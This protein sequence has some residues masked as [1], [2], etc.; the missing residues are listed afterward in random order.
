MDEHKPLDSKNGR[1]C[2]GID[3]RRFSVWTT[4]V[5]YRLCCGERERHPH[6]GVRRVLDSVFRE[7][8]QVKTEG[9]V[10]S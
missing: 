6:A 8:I 3:E 2:T 1:Y 10:C 9:S 5:H 7:D 4:L